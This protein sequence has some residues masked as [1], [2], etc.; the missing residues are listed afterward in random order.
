[1]QECMLLFADPLVFI[2]ALVAFLL[3]VNIAAAKAKRLQEEIERLKRK[4]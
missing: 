2:G 3:F 4:R 1:M